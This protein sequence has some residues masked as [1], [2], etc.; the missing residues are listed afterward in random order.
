[1][2]MLICQ[3]I[4][5]AGFKI[6]GETPSENR[7]GSKLQLEMVE[8]KIEAN[9]GKDVRELEEKNKRYISILLFKLLEK[10]KT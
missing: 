6:T 3:A 7:I 8:I 1:M 2:F 5:N 9:V 4:V 10:Y